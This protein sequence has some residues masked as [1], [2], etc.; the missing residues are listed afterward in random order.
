LFWEQLA[1]TRPDCYR[2]RVTT[3]VLATRNVHKVDEI[4][5]ILGYNFC[6]LTLNDFPAAPKVVED[7]ETF[8]GNA[9]K[10]AVELARCLASAGSRFTIHDSST[11]FVLADD[12]GLEVDALDGTP[13]VHSARFAAMDSAKSGNTPDADNNAKL[14]RLLKNVPLEKRAARFRCVIALAPVPAEKTE[15][16]SPVCYADEFQAQTFDGVCEGEII[17]EP[18]GKNGFGYDPLFVPVGFEQTFAELGED[19]KN[20]LSHRA[21]ALEKLKIFFSTR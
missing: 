13:G 2:P 11:N 14:L 10:K 17:F 20:K 15:S 21:Q 3:L 7:A 16:A 4:R 6:F 12:S 18:R 5:A 1:K 9:T 19:V 8:A